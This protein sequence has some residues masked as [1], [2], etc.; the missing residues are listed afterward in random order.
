M[1]EWDDVCD[2]PVYSTAERT[3]NE[4]VSACTKKEKSEGVR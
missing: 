3:Q 2:G 1:R 4:T